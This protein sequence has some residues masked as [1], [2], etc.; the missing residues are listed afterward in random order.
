MLLQV[1][2][3]R[4][5]REM[6]GWQSAGRP[7]QTSMPHPVQI[8]LKTMRKEGSFKQIGFDTKI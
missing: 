8:F 3:Q 6:L 4:W 7:I 1:Y 2:E 5:L